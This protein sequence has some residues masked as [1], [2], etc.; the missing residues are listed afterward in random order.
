M[1]AE[2]SIIPLDKGKSVSKEVAEVLDIV[3]KSGLSYSLT[4]MGTIVEGSWD[5]V[6]ALIKRCHRKVLTSSCRVYTKISIDDK[7]GK[8]N[9]L[10]Q[11]VKSVEEKLSRKLKH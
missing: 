5:E 3:D 11:K 9:L 6:L 10:R 1:L 8:H 2:F 7:K 4:P